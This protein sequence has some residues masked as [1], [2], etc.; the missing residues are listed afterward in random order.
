MPGFGF[1]RDEKNRI[2]MLHVK[3]HTYTL[4]YASPRRRDKFYCYIPG[5]GYARSGEICFP[6]RRSCA[7]GACRYNTINHV[8]RDLNSR[9]PATA[10]GSGGRNR[11]TTAIEGLFRLLER[12]TANSGAWNLP[13][14]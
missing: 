9:S 10:N 14:R 4:V 2:D 12:P 13:V 5:I 3:L 1:G 6:M 7:A 8:E 11:R